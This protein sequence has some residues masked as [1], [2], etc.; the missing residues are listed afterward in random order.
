MG[1]LTW[2]QIDVSSWAVAEVEQEG[3]TPVQWLL[4]PGTP[5]LKDPDPPRRWLHKDTV[6]PANRVEQGEDWAEVVATQVA[7]AL[8]VPCA[9]TMMCLRR[10]RRGTLSLNVAPK[11]N[12]LWRGR[13]FFPRPMA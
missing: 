13:F 1:S 10:G 5:S 6:I 8:E 3:S 7:I 11:G 4:E 12:S 2:D 9:A